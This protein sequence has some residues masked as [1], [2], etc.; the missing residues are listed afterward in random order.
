[1][2][3]HFAE[4]LNPYSRDRGKLH[5]NIVTFK[6]KTILSRNENLCLS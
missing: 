4:M 2:R 1:M 6:R 5:Q 3:I